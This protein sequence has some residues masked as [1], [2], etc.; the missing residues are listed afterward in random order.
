VDLYEEGATNATRGL[1]LLIEDCVE[2]GYC[3]DDMLEMLEDIV[4]ELNESPERVPLD[5]SLFGLSDAPEDAGVTIDGDTFI[6]ILFQS[7]YA[8]E[9]TRLIPDMIYDA[10]FGDFGTASRV[11]I[12]GLGQ[13]IISF[14]HGMHLSVQ[15]A[16]E[17]PFSSR[18]EVTGDE[19]ANKLVGGFM[20]RAH[21]SVIRSCSGWGAAK[22]GE[23]E[24]EA[25]KS[26]IPTLILAGEYDPVTPPAWGRLVNENLS[27]SHFLE[28]PGIGHGVTHSHACPFGIT[29]EFLDEPEAAPDSAC[30]EDM[31]VPAYGE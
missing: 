5:F 9:L 24:N 22:P 17:V 3:T 10:D 26:D 16:D 20:R 29:L 4:V 19:K 28:F 13:Q 2:D 8:P 1:T 11:L 23:S 14:S 21:Q 31:G 18:D 25:V 7:L 27:S 12:T 6:G 15:C 30:I